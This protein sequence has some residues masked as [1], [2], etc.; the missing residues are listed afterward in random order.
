MEMT[1]VPQTEVDRNVG[2]RNVYGM[3]EAEELMK[4]PSSATL[5]EERGLSRTTQMHSVDL[6]KHVAL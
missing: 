1:T 6:N 5:T 3:S 4:M 2:C